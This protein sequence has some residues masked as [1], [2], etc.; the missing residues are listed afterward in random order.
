MG[1]V[2]ASTTSHAARLA[3]WARAASSSFAAA[4]AFW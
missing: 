4:M 2:A 1:E 3:A